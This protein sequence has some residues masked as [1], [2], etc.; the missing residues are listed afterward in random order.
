MLDTVSEPKTGWAGVSH[1]DQGIVK[2]IHDHDEHGTCV[3]WYKW[4][5]SRPQLFI[6]VDELRKNLAVLLIIL[7]YILILQNTS[8][9]WLVS[10]QILT[11]ISLNNLTLGSCESD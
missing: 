2:L 7:K 5:N 10:S 6:L 8:D 4:R 11:P 3:I 9:C 1:K